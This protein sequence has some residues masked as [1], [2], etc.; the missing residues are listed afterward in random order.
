MGGKIEH[1]KNKRIQNETGVKYFGYFSLKKFINLLDQ[2]DLV[3]TAVTMATHLAIALKKKIVLFNNI[4]NKNEFELYNLGKILE[5]D[6][7]ECYYK[8]KCDKECM[9]Q[10][11]VSKVFDTI[12]EILYLN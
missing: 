10:I 11:K 6:E 8:P 7:C 5:P 12:K 3:V 1:K 9:R 4:F 2:C